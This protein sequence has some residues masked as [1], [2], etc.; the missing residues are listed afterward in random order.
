MLLLVIWKL[1]ENAYGVTIAELLSRISGKEWVLGAIY[2]PL[3]R[4]ENKGYLTSQMG[5][6][7]STRGGRRKR[8]YRLTED[9]FQSLISTKTLEHTL[10]K[11]ISLAK[12][13]EGYET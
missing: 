5:T 1:G 3:E 11:D 12:L 8:L 9:A 7:S 13:E 10:W 2:V 6:P 4:L